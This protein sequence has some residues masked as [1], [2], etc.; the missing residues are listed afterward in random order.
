[1]IHL[2][3]TLIEKFDEILCNN[4]NAAELTMPTSVFKNYIE[5]KSHIYRRFNSFFVKKDIVI[6]KSDDLSYKQFV[7]NDFLEQVKNMNFQVDIINNFLNGMLQVSAEEFAENRF[8]GARLTKYMKSILPTAYA[9]MCV[10]NEYSRQLSKFKPI[11][12]Q[13]VL[14]IHPID[15]ITMSESGYNW[16]SCQSL[17]GDYAAGTLA[18]MA[19]DCT[20]V[21]Y[22][23][24]KT[25]REFSWGYWWPKKWRMLIHVDPNHNLFVFNRQYPYVLPEAENI[26]VEM[27][28]DIWREKHFGFRKKYTLQ[29]KYNFVVS[30]EDS[31]HY[32]DFNQHPPT[33]LATKDNFDDETII[34]GEAIHCFE[35]HYNYMTEAGLFKC[36]DC[37]GLFLEC[38]ACGESVSAEE[39]LHGNNTV[40]G[41]TYSA[42]YCE[43]CH[44]ENNQ[45]E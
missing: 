10:E 1:M 26:V 22:I 12:G 7:Y 41:R 19:D 38:H 6:D 37:E 27:I 33:V 14:S 25:K 15:Y 18:L 29:D 2:D 24:T 32:S 23:S 36:L 5:N 4:S 39:A 31:V 28:Q 45:E 44:E 30:H 35:C 43:S 34:I 11:S 42:I 13:M 17:E 8:N 20:I 16:S 40:D 3:N 9:K 21:A